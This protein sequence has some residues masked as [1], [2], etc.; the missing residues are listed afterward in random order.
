MDS[1]IR[2]LNR[3]HRD[4]THEY[5]VEQ[6]VLLAEEDDSQARQRFLAMLETD[7]RYICCRCGRVQRVSKTNP[8]RLHFN[9][10]QKPF[11]NETT[12]DLCNRPHRG[13]KP[14]TPPPPPAPDGERPDFTLWPRRRVRPPVVGP[15]KTEGE[16][17]RR[18]TRRESTPQ[19]M[20]MTLIEHNG[21]HTLPEPLPEAAIWAHMRATLEAM[22]LVLPRGSEIRLS[23]I[24]YLPDRPSLG[25]VLDAAHAIRLSWPPREVDAPIVWVMGITGRPPRHRP[26]RMYEVDFTDCS[27]RTE[28]IHVRAQRLRRRGRPQSPVRP[29]YLVFALG[30]VD[31]WGQVEFAQVILQPI[32]DRYCPIPVDSGHEREVLHLL[33]ARGVSVV[34]PLRPSAEGLHPDVL[35]PDLQAYVEVQGEKSQKYRERK[36][37]SAIVE[38]YASSHE[39]TGWRPLLHFRNEGD[40]LADFERELDLLLG[41]VGHSPASSAAAE[42]PAS[43]RGRACRDDLPDAAAGAGYSHV[44]GPG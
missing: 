26:G 43:G 6:V 17:K 1:D 18:R 9:P 12:C 8:H 20:L 37:R 16:S 25:G 2:I 34:R 28:R 3:K 27:G 36:S 4:V 7:G 35:L 22:P 44:G 42:P 24:T 39:F 14:E 31:G 11:T 10:G 5:E 29:P 21:W 13:E 30:L 41:S 23:E 40:S 15:T 33:Q 32:L 19:R 38:R